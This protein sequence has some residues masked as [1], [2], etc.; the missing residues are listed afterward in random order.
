MSDYVF[1]YVIEHGDR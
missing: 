1:R